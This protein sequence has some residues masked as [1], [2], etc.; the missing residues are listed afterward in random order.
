LQS[1]LDRCICFFYY[2]IIVLLI[3]EVSHSSEEQISRS[4]SPWEVIVFVF[5]LFS[6]NSLF[7]EIRLLII[8]Y[9][10]LCPGV[11]TP[12]TG[13]RFYSRES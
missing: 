11:F 9:R 5:L 4:Q 13:L 1:A 12:A 8:P 7:V 6:Y 3:D 2:S 10:Y